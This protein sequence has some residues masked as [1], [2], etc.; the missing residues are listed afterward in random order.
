MRKEQTSSF[1]LRYIK[2]KEEA[3][4]DFFITDITTRIG[5]DQIMEIE[6]INLVV[7]F[8]MGRIT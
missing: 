4:Q 3:K 5:I 1:N 2:V 6:E 7:E 8:N